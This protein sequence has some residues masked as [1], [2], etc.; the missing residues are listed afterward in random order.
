MIFEKNKF[1]SLWKEPG[2]ARVEKILRR[3][4]LFLNFFCLFTHSYHPFM[5]NLFEFLITIMYIIFF[6]PI[7]LLTVLFYLFSPFARTYDIFKDIFYNNDVSQILFADWFV[8]LPL[9]KHVLKVLYVTDVKG[10]KKNTRWRN[11]L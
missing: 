9:R 10:K 5:G 8:E 11:K 6:H 4:I 2:C 3:L 7:L 1:K